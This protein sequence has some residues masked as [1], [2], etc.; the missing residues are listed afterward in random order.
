MAEEIVQYQRQAP[1]IEERAEQ[2]LGSIYG[3]PVAPG[4]A[5]P[6]KLEGE[7]EE[8]YQLRIK[9]L[10]GIPQ[11][12]AAKQVAPLEQAQLTAIQEAQAGLGAYRPFLQQAEQTV[13]A[14]LG[15]IGAG[16]Q[17]L[18]PRQVST[19]MDPYQQQV[20]QQALAELQRQADIQSQR[21]AAEAVAAGAFGGSRFGVR[22]AEEAR[23]L[24]QVKSQRIFEDLSRNYL[25]AQQAQQQTAQQLGQ[26]GVQTLQAG[27]AQAG[28]GELG[29][30]LSG[31]DINRLLSVGGVQQQQQQ[32]VMEAA[33][34]TEL[35]RQQEPY[36]RAGFASDILRGIPSSSI[37]YTQQ[38]SPSMF[39]QVAGLGIA[40]LSTL[41]ALG[42]FGGGVSALG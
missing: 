40:G 35:A 9:G 19:Y 14:G 24:A 38:P 16:V 28:L 21:T 8:Q 33:R 32:N 3:V 20:T 27:Q 26:L 41:G 29:Q 5:P 25:Q 17:T 12:V 1:F 31:V 4:E 42:V 34:Q 22:E 7:T 37:A 10:A 18:D 39:Q 13:G 11:A 23:N 2:L 6:P 36:R 30:Q 15:A